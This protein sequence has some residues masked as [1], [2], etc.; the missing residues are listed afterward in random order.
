MNFHDG[1]RDWKP[2]EWARPAVSEGA[3]GITTRMID[4]HIHPRRYLVPV[5][6]HRRDKKLAG[7]KLLQLAHGI[8]PQLLI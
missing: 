7:K 2:E 6:N 5:L 1:D 8:T 3:A 4:P